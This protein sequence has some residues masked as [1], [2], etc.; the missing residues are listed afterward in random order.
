MIKT[1][2]GLIVEFGDV[3]ALS[4]ETQLFEIWVV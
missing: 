1:M 4:E 2:A 3:C